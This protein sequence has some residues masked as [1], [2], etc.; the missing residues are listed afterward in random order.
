MSFCSEGEVVERIRGV[1]GVAERRLRFAKFN[2][3]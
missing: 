1:E 3:G 2:Q